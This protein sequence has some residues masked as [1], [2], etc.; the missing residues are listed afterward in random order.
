MVKKIMSYSPSGIKPSVPDFTFLTATF[1][2]QKGQQAEAREQQDNT[3][4]HWNIGQTKQLVPGH[5]SH[6]GD[7]YGSAAIGGDQPV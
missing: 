7:A 4:G 6:L 1:T 5:E 3:R 2:S